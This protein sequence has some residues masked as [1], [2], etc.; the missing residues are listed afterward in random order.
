QENTGRH[1]PPMLRQQEPGCQPLLWDHEKEPV[2]AVVRGAPD[3]G[4][5]A[6]EWRKSRFFARLG[7]QNGFV[8]PG[9]QVA[10]GR[11]RQNALAR[12]DR[13][14]THFKPLQSWPPVAL[15]RGAR[16]F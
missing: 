3:H 13:L 4:S 7:Q 12:K 16:L 2:S 6:P 15:V 9:E 14:E 5:A 1:S 11:I 10:P 8:R